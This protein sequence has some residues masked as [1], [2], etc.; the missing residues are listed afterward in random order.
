MN[1]GSGVS[2]ISTTT[3]V[4]LGVAVVTILV[5]VV[6]ATTVYF[7]LN[8]KYSFHMNELRVFFMIAV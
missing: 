3:Q 1:R 8:G 4:I 7:T 5:V 6:I 2:G